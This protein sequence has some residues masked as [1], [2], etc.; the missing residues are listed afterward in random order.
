MEKTILYKNT[1]LLV[2]ILYTNLVCFYLKLAVEVST[3]LLYLLRTETKT[4]FSINPPTIFIFMHLYIT[5]LVS[6]IFIFTY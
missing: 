5:L 1:N 3:F 4:N 6:C 2:L